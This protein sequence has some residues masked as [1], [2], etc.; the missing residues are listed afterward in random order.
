MH[1][2]LD[3]VPRPTA[4][5][6]SFTV[7]HGRGTVRAPRIP[8]ICTIAILRPFPHIAGHVIQA[9]GIGLLAGDLVS[10]P[11]AVA[12]VPGYGFYFLATAVFVRPACP[13]GVFPLGITRQPVPS[14]AAT[15]R[16]ICQAL[17]GSGKTS[18]IRQD[19]PGYTTFT[20]CP[21]VL[22]T[23]AS[24]ELASRYGFRHA[25]CS[26]RFQASGGEYRSMST[27]PRPSSATM[28]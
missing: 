24:F 21:T 13:T 15:G 27:V 20:D 1:Q 11:V 23:F 19:L 7:A 17:H 5:R 16:P 4:N 3:V 9:P 8:R 22:R 14:Q 18:A 2:P 25:Q 10:C 12:F 26:A 6:V 28:R